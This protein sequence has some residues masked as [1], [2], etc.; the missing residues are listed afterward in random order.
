MNLDITESPGARKNYERVLTGAQSSGN[1]ATVT[2]ARSNA[3][4]HTS[5]APSGTSRLVPTNATGSVVGRIDPTH[6]HHGKNNQ[7]RR[8][9]PL[10]YF[11]RRGDEKH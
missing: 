10:R 5:T 4:A 1:R 11:D 2:A 8:E 6:K 9:H 7:K 3:N